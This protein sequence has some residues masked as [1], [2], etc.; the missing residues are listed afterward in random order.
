M[1]ITG[2]VSASVCVCVWGGGGCV[3]VCVCSYV[4]IILYQAEEQEEAGRQERREGKEGT[5]RRRKR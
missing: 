1:T 4:R 5:G 3:C 2:Y